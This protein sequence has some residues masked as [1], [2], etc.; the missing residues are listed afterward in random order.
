MTQ[1]DRHKRDDVLTTPA[2]LIAIRLSKITAA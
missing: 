1:D 2:S